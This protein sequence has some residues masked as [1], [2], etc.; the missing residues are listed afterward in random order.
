MISFKTSAF[1]SVTL[2]A[3]AISV[4][5]PILAPLSRVLHLTEIQIGAIVSTGSAVMAVAGLLWG[6]LSDRIGRQPIMMIGFLGVG[7]SYAVYTWLT[8]LG[9]NGKLVAGS[10]F[11]ALLLSRAVIGVFLPAAPASAQALVADNTSDAE[12][13]AGMAMIGA[14]NGL[15]MVIGPV[16][17][18]VL[19]LKGLIWPLFV[20]TIVSLL[21]FLFVALFVPRTR[22]V[23]RG[24]VPKLD[25]RQRGMWR[26]LIAGF[27]TFMSIITMQISAAFYIQDSLAITEEQTAPILAAGLFCVGLVM[28]LTQIL[29]MKVLK[30]SPRPLAL[31][32]AGLWIVGLVML[33]SFQSPM[34]Y[35]A[36][37]CVLGVGNGLIFP[38]MMA[39]A[40]LCA[41]AHHQ[42]SVAGLIAA[43]QGLASI[44]VP[45]GSTVLYHMRPELPFLLAMVG[46]FLV[47]VLFAAPR[48]AALHPVD[49]TAE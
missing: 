48:T 39:G 34:A 5:L 7:L 12:R 23:L 25:P 22:P 6:R 2:S 41:D 13:S 35:Y 14:A 30:L 43:V 46:M 44:L 29:Q 38:G 28:I 20:T 3:M 47:F 21:A 19:A 8:W 32:G 36:A 42:G 10:L 40:S 31:I 4:I 1:V 17:G 45:I 33:L 11:I 37:Y 26:W 27:M 24:P 18:G 49:N 9:V 15:G 16:I